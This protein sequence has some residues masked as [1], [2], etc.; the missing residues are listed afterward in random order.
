MK[1]VILAGGLGTRI[2]EETVIRPK[3]M[4]EIGGMPIL[5]HIM[6]FYSTY[7][8]T[9]FIICC[10]YKGYMIK[11]YFVNYMRHNSDISIDMV[12]EK[13]S[14]KKK[15]IEPWNIELVDT[16]QDALTADRVKAVKHLL[17]E[18]DFCMTYGDGLSNIDLY[19]EI[20]FH[21]SHGKLATVAAVQPPGRFGRLN[22]EQ[23]N[24][25]GFEE[26]PQNG[27]DFINGGFFILS[28]KC[29]DLIVGN[30][31]WEDGPM[32]KLA[33]MRQLMAFHHNGFWQPMDTLREKNLLENLWEAG[34]A[35]WKTW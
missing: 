6:K 14:Y 20:E 19:K 23:N 15:N 31:A 27:G 9:D 25:T 4:V 13:I 24:V 8:I 10:G 22:I 2:S 18:Q 34:A 5:W 29:L 30:E 28:P 32:N 7:A 17:G 26:K 35:P 33:E 1:L 3:P 21:K 16:G 12:N 11:E